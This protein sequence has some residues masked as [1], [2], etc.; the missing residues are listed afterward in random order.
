MAK[1][2]T[3][4]QANERREI[5]K[6]SVQYTSVI[7]LE[8]G[9]SFDGFMTIQFNANTNDKPLHLDFSNGKVL[10]LSLNGKPWNEEKVKDRHKKDLILIKSGE[11]E[12]ESQNVIQVKYINVYSTDGFG[13][14]SFTDVDKSQYVY[15]QNQPFYASSVSPVF[16]Q[17]D[18]KGVFILHVTVNDDWVC[19]S[20]SPIESKGSKPAE[21]G[22]S[23]KF[24]KF[25]NTSELPPHLMTFAAGPFKEIPCAEKDLAKPMSLYVRKSLAEHADKQKDKI[26]PYVIEGLKHLKDY[27]KTPLPFDKTDLIFLPEVPVKS[28]QGAGLIA[29]SDDYISRIQEENPINHSRRAQLLLQG[30]ASF[31]FGSCVTMQWWSDM[32]VNDALSVF[33]SYQTLENIELKFDRVKGWTLFQ[34]D[35]HQAY[36]KDALPTA[37][38]LYWPVKTASQAMILYDSI[39]WHKGAAVLRQLLTRI[40]TVDFPNALILYLTEYKF[41]SASNEQFFEQVKKATGNKEK[42]KNIE[43]F[44]TQWVEA[45][46]HN[47]LEFRFDPKQDDTEITVKQIP[48]LD[49]FGTLRYHT[50]TITGADKDDKLTTKEFLI[51]NKEETKLSFGSTLQFAT[52]NV[53]EHTFAEIN[54][55]ASS[56]LYILS[57][58]KEIVKAMPELAIHHFRFFLHS[59]RRGELKA[60]HALEDIKTSYLNEEKASF[61]VLNYV[62]KVFT[63]IADLYVPRNKSGQLVESIINTVV[64]GTTDK[65]PKSIIEVWAQHLPRLGR[66]HKANLLLKDLFENGI[67][68]LKSAELSHR[69]LWQILFSLRTD[70]EFSERQIRMFQN[71]L[72]KNDISEQREY[73]RRAIT[74]F[75]LDEEETTK[76]LDSFRDKNASS[77]LGLI[78][79]S[80]LG[81]NSLSRSDAQM[82]PVNQFFNAD[83]SSVINNLP[84]WKAKTI[85]EGV[86]PVSEEFLKTIA[87][88]DRIHSSIA[89]SHPFFKNL[90]MEQVWIIK[91]RKR[92]FEG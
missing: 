67:P 74:A 9:Q 56:T 32:W 86:L 77:C 1:N 48:V 36:E 20:N 23:S 18:I 79:A 19:V 51:Q 75:S 53:D 13:L 50:V 24:F 14:H 78:K 59:I 73:G 54:L 47:L 37:R 3:E 11:Y 66:T 65:T 52:I 72:E 38:P 31:W 64:N 60:E 6:G 68:V 46:G 82:E 2:L 63:E 27:L 34:T 15:C 55:P 22:K 89:D 44:K 40:G 88:L 10:S 29:V 5:I 91:N 41:K 49:E 81:L 12:T 8:L 16:D 62:L 42:E 57:K 25:K 39:T 71:Y 30:L 45:A 58:M 76:L 83:V 92:A 80:L 7:N 28:I 87:T 33:L 69:Q 17:P 35:N 85:F 90:I 84:L 26:F 43:I 61:W 21:N 70:K 4:T